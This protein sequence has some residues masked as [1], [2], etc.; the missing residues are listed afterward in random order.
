MAAASTAF[1]SHLLCWLIFSEQR[2]SFTKIER[3]GEAKEPQ[4]YLSSPI[5]YFNSFHFAITLS[6]PSTVLLSPYPFTTHLQ[7][8]QKIFLRG[9][10]ASPRFIGISRVFEGPWSWEKP[11]LPPTL[12]SSPFSSSSNKK[13]LLTWKN[14]SA[15]SFGLSSPSRMNHSI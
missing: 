12:T 4:V 3:G 13:F 10:F 9:S 15:F 5:Y 11:T 2:S 14:L 6:V 1:S 8:H 7:T